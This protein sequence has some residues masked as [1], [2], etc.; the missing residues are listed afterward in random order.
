MLYS[1]HPKRLGERHLGIY[2]FVS[3][4]GNNLSGSGPPRI[5]SH[6]EIVLTSLDE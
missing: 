5:F 6:S 4:L 1:M 2:L 3:R